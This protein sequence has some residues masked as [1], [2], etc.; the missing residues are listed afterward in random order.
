MYLDLFLGLSPDF[1]PIVTV[2][3]GKKKIF[4]FTF[5]FFGVSNCVLLGLVATR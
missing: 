1:L 2:M 3:K 4:L 5:P